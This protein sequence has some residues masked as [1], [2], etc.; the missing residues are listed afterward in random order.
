LSAE[1]RRRFRLLV[2][3]THPIQYRAPLYRRLS[4]ED[5]LD[6]EVWYGD[7]YGVR[8]TAS[9]WGVRDFRWDTDLVSGYRHRFLRNTAR[10][11][12]P[13]HAAGIYNPGLGGEVARTAPDAV[14]V[15]GYASLHSWQSLLGA[16]RAKVPV[17]YAS[18]SN[19]LAEPRG[20]KGALKRVVVPRVYRRIA[21][22]LVSGTTNDLHY[23]A[24]GVPAEKRFPFPWAIDNER[25]AN[26][27]DEARAV[28][29]EIRARWG[30]AEGRDVVLF[31]GRL[32][33]EKD[34]LTLLRA[35]QSDPRLHMVVAGSGPLDGEVGRVA[36]ERLA[37][38]FTALGFVNQGAM[39][40][41]YAAADLLVLPSRFEPWGLVV[42]E[43]L[44]A[45][46]PVVAADRVG[47]AHD[48]VPPGFRFRTGDPADLARAIEAWRGDRGVRSDPVGWARDRVRGFTFDAD[49]RGL[50]EACARV[51][52]G[53]PAAAAF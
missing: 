32:S 45:G 34:P 14:W 5:W 40:S 24:Y 13:V 51:A 12:G 47:A 28:R 31:S 46:C 21:A 41:V 49:A 1:T 52:A 25:Y 44:A 6:L 48:L 22:F 20:V 8:P 27:A 50:R 9:P 36:A 29:D 15:S 23:E 26:A 16:W 53:T 19:V 42:N 11:P 37:G 2:L 17:L 30:V 3:A 4:D 38:R 43:A 10:R 35:A 33:P 18:D 7:D 39:P